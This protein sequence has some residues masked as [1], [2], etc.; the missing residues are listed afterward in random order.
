MIGCRSGSQWSG[1][2]RVGEL[3]LAPR[4]FSMQESMTIGGY[5]VGSSARLE[6]P[7]SIEENDED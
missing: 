3:F 6:C 4:E 1:L 5:N 7:L 2:A